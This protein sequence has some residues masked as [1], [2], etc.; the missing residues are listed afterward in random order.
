MILIKEI[1]QTVIKTF[2]RPP[3]VL[4]LSQKFERKHR[5]VSKTIF[6]IKEPYY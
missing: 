3:K 4:F 2:F 5:G 6:P 1:R